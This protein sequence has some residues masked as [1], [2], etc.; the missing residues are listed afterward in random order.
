MIPRAGVL[1]SEWLT[2]PWYATLTAFVAVN[3]LVYVV[4]SVSKIL[5]RVHP[6]TWLRR[7]GTS[8]RRE[9]RS[10][11]PERTPSG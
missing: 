5:P 11:Y 8:R 3:T 9:T 6:S 7:G 4:L 10:I 2:S 1:P